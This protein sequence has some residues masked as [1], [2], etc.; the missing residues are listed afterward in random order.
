MRIVIA[1][2]GLMALVSVP[3][4][5]AWRVTLK[6]GE[7]LTVESYWR[8]GDK[9]HLV[10]GGVDVIVDDARIESLE[11]GAP[12]PETNVQSATARTE[13]D[14]E[15]AAPTSATAGPADAEPSETGKQYQERLGEMTEEE[16]KAEEDRATNAL[17]AAQ[18]KRFQARYA[19]TASK[20]DVKAANAAFRNAQQR[21]AVAEN[22]LKERMAQ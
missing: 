11:D 1:V 6:T 3:A 18:A 8:E 5:A 9:V 20:E 7:V 17:L 16:L 22:A 14:E 2:L 10:R 19:R 13:T 12:A 15:T 21:E 4:H